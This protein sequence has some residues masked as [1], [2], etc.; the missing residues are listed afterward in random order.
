MSLE[1]EKGM[2]RPGIDKEQETG[3]TDEPIPKERGRPRM[4][5]SDRTSDESKSETGRAPKP[6]NPEG[7]M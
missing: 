6:S 7:S 3:V 4:D 2:V 1:K 5:E